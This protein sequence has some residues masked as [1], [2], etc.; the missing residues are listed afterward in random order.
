M[1]TPSASRQALHG[2]G[3]HPIE[4]CEVYRP[5]R[6]RDVRSVVLEGG[7]SRLIARGNGRAYGDAALNRDAG[8][9]EATRLDRMLDFDAETGLLHCEAGVTLPDVIDL[10]LP[11]GYFFPVTPGTKQIS[12]GGAVAADVHGK[13][14]HR[15]GSIGRHLRE[16][17]VLLADGER[18]TCSREV[19]PD[20]FH[21]TVGGMGLTGVVL[22]AKVQ[23]KRV[24]TAWV[25]GVTTRTRGLEETL[26]RVIED[27][28]RYGYAVSW[29]DCQKR[30]RGM[31]RA[32]LLRADEAR[33]SELPEVSRDEPLRISPPTPLSVPF[34]LPSGVMNRWATGLFNAAYYAAN[35]P[36]EAIANYERYFYPLDAIHHWNRVYGSGGVLQYQIVV[37]AE[38]ARVTMT[39]VVERIVEAKRPTFLGVIKTLGEQ[40]DGLLSFPRPGLTLSV[41]FPYPD[42]ALRVLLQGLDEL[43]LEAGGRVYLAKDACLRAEHARAMYP[44]FDRFRE[45]KRRYDP[46]ER[47]SSSL[48]R[49]LGLTEAA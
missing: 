38:H 48:S 35:G 37:P 15:D 1:K 33:L 45:I 7:A 19:E 26:E 47:F 24:E 22:D 6:S 28:P 27:D 44:G 8:V 34:S 36:G 11:R 23:L 13:N 17:T 9:L 49:R 41:D 42:D 3:R 14:H 43:V 25:R 29:I 18:V 31:G 21:A 10:L 16:L 30:G 4:A 5:E 32:V 20:L 12:I 39:R 46:E 2:W 40:G